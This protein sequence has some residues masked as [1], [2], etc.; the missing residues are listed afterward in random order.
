MNFQSLLYWLC[1]VILFSACKSKT[2]HLFSLLPAG[3]TGIYFENK[4]EDTDTL[5]ILDYLYYYNGAGVA[6]GDINNDGL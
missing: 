5:N 1:T 4:I 2:A 3:K 6:I